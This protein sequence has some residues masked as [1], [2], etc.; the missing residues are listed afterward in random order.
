MEFSISNFM[1]IGILF[2]FHALVVVAVVLE[3]DDAIVVKG[4]IKNYLKNK[5]THLSL[6]TR[7]LPYT[8]C[9]AKMLFLIIVIN[10]CCSG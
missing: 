3:T 8:V 10:Y 6:T 9:D 7:L 2:L 1:S 4:S 5:L